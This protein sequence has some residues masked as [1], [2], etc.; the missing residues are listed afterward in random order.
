MCL[1][2][3]VGGMAALDS[4]KEIKDATA[5]KPVRQD[6]LIIA[7]YVLTRVLVLTLSKLREHRLVM[8]ILFS[9]R[10]LIS[11]ELREL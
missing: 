7:A 10:C 9:Q 5:E 4:L 2:T 11:A 8:R 3:H 6:L 1:Q